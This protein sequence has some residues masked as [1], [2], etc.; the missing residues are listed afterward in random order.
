MPLS[1]EQLRPEALW[2]TDWD[3]QRL[4]L[5]IGWTHG[6]AALGVVLVILIESGRIGGCII[7]E[8]SGRLSEAPVE[9]SRITA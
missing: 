3:T 5:T 7:P 4:F 2:R 6:Y 8:R 1:A 9:L